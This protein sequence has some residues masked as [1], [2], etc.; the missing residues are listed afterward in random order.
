AN[1]VRPAGRAPGVPVM[2]MTTEEQVTTF[3]N[4]SPTTAWPDE[5]GLDGQRN[6]SA[7]QLHGQVGV[8]AG[9]GGYRSAY[10]QSDIPVGRAGT[11]S[12]FLQETRSGRGHGYR[13]SGPTETSLG[14]NLEMSAERRSRACQ[15]A[16]GGRQSWPTVG[17]GQLTCVTRGRPTVDGY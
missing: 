14:L 1:D 2:P 13:F 16:P 5:Q 12:I 3:L 8:S 15:D 9:T 11:L 6:A 10:A 17:Q 7:R 4:A